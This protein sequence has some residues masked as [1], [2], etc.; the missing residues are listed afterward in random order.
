MDS[1]LCAQIDRA[2]SLLANGLFGHKGTSGAECACP[3]PLDE[4]MR[5]SFAEEGTRGRSQATRSKAAAVCAYAALCTGLAVA[6]KRSSSHRGVT[7]GCTSAA[8]PRT[9]TSARGP[10]CATK[11]PSVPIPINTRRLCIEALAGSIQRACAVASF[12]L[13]DTDRQAFIVR[14]HRFTFRTIFRIPCCC[15]FFAAVINVRSHVVIRGVRRPSRAYHKPGTTGSLPGRTS[16]V[17]LSRERCNDKM[18]CDGCVE[19][20]ICSQ[21]VWLS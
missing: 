3:V 14:S 21:P 12:A 8:C 7:T 10:R 11:L 2:S 13:L 6:H 5:K 20:W 17:S 4:R 18:C 1:Y 16:V 15:A 19:C 9:L